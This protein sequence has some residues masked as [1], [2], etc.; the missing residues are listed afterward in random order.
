MEGGYHP[1][2]PVS[3]AA[4]ASARLTML[5]PRRLSTPLDASR[6]LGHERWNAPQD[7]GTDVP[8]PI[9]H[10]QHGQS[11]TV[12]R[13]AAALLYS[14]SC[15]SITHVGNGVDSQQARCPLPQHVARG[16]G[17]MRRQKAAALTALDISH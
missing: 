14:F 7:R 6:P 4:Q 10:R 2:L 8:A 12:R 16:S 11:D 3:G 17:E 15:H 13:A 5:W 1:P 9:S